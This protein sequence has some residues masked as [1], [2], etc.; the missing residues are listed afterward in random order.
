[1]TARSIVRAIALTAVAASALLAC[2]TK[3]AADAGGVG[4]DESAARIS[5]GLT[6][7]GASPERSACFAGKIASI[8]NAPDAAEAIDIIDR[9]TS[10][11][12]MRSGVLGASAPV[13]QSFIRAHFG[14]SFFD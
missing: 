7:L 12:D 4:A 10:K 9:S 11:D 14:C 8:L 3:P 6:R 2:S 5:A 13:K 1:M